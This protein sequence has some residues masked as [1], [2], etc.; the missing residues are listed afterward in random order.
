MTKIPKSAPRTV[1]GNLEFEQARDFI[2]AQAIPSMSA[3][4]KWHAI[5]KPKM[6]PKY[7]QRAYSKDWKGWNDF[8]G[9]E[10]SNL[11]NRIAWRPYDEAIIYAHSLQL[12]D[13][14]SWFEFS[15]SG[16]MP[17]DIPSRPDLYYDEWMGWDVWLGKT[18]NAKL[19]VHQAVAKSNTIFYVIR[20]IDEVYPSNVYTFGVSKVG[21]RPL[22]EREIEG[23]IQ[24]IG[25]YRYEES[26]AAYAQQV[27]NDTTS[28][29]YGDNK[30]RISPNIYA[31][32]WNLSMAMEP[33]DLNTERSLI[34]QSRN[35]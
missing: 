19:K 27:V 9:N 35:Q 12:P 2:R 6:L 3:Y 14:A 18:A 25:A 22:I 23:K 34:H 31:T 10:N 29:W 5:N 26:N 11:P 15:K 32:C 21:I 20:I 4:H 28:E 13:S 33:I 7:P 24:V 30:I 1:N 17:I 16:E 8:L